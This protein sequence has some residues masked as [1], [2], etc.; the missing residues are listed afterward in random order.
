MRRSNTLYIRLFSDFLALRRAK[1]MGHREK[2]LC[3]TLLYYISNHRCGSSL[4]RAKTTATNSATLGRACERDMRKCRKQRKCKA[5][6]YA[7]P[8]EQTEDIMRRVAHLASRKWTTYSKCTRRRKNESLR[9]NLR[10]SISER[11][12]RL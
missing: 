7:K 4:K 6:K 11:L 1:R 3:T 12:V 2:G 8:R 9:T 10:L 5:E